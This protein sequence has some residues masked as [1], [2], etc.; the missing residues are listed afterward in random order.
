MIRWLSRFGLLG[1]MLL[2]ACPK[3]EDGGSKP[4]PK[5]LRS[6][7]T[8]EEAHETLKSTLDLAATEATVRAILAAEPGER[9]AAAFMSALRATADGRLHEFSELPDDAF[10]VPEPERVRGPGRAFV[11]H[12]SAPFLEAGQGSEGSLTQYLPVG[13]RVRVLEVEED[14]ARVELDAW[15][16]RKATAATRS[17]WMLGEWS[18]L[19]DPTDQMVARLAGTGAKVSPP[20][21]PALARPRTGVVPLRMLGTSTLTP[22]RLSGEAGR[23][24]GSVSEHAYRL[25]RYIASEPRD[26]TKQKELLET[27]LEA[28]LY[29]LALLA[30]DELRILSDPEERFEWSMVI[31]HHAFC[32]GKVDRSQTEWLDRVP[33]LRPFP[34]A[35][36]EVKRT[37]ELA[38]RYLTEPSFDAASPSHGTER[39]L[40]LVDAVLALGPSGAIRVVGDSFHSKHCDTPLVDRAAILTCLDSQLGKLDE[41]TPPEIVRA[42]RALTDAARTAE[43]EIAFLGWKWALREFAPDE[44]QDLDAVLNCLPGP[45]TEPSEGKGPSGL[46]GGDTIEGRTKRWLEET[47]RRFPR[48]NLLRISLTN[49]RALPAAPGQESLL[50]R[51]S[52]STCD[53]EARPTGIEFRRLPALVVPPRGG[54]DLLVQVPRPVGAGVEFAATFE[55]AVEGVEALALPEGGS[56]DEGMVRL[57]LDYER[58]CERPLPESSFARRFAPQRPCCCK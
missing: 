7:P 17:V 32:R 45:R 33:E 27:A 28:G 29:P 42:A 49:R 19:E 37:S 2:V 38:G 25:A 41:E 14:R 23:T 20:V 4:P 30:A 31:D 47:R 18:K 35:E 11:H 51:F 56:S 26:R 16:P 39:A 3:T 36:Y 48:S 44:I 34:A 10:A 8:I 58:G 55:Q 52:G 1:S 53:C 6:A 5:A 21:A 43:G 40:C 15:L 50:Y 57:C 13:T 54:L 12:I 9:R 46:L 24:T 22:G